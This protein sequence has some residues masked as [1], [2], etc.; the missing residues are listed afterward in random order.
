VRPAGLKAQMPSAEGMAPSGASCAF[1]RGLVPPRPPPKPPAGLKSKSENKGGLPIA[2]F[3]LSIKIISRGKGKSA[4]AAAAYRAGELIK[5]EY[6]GITHD[7]TRKGG[8]V[9]TEIMLPDNAPPEYADRATLWNSVEQVEKSRN[10][11]LAREIEIALPVE[12]TLPQNKSLVHDYIK[13][14]FVYAGICAD[15][16]IHDTGNGNPHAHIMLTMRPIEKNG[17]W[18][19]KAKKE[20]IL[21]DSGERVRL[22]SGEFKSRKVAAVDWNNQDKAEQWRAS[23]ADAV[24]TALEQRK[25]ESRID[26]RSYERQGIDRI[27]TIHLGVAA[28]Q[29]ERK[30]ISTNRGDINRE[31]EITNSQL[32][33]LEARINKLKARLTEESKFRDVAD[34]ETKVMDMHGKQR[35][36]SSKLND[37]EQRIK[38]LDEHIKQAG[39]YFEFR[40][41]YKKYKEVKPR[42]QEDYHENNRR[43]LALYESAERYLNGIMNGKTG[44]PVNAWKAER[45]KLTAEKNTLYQKYYSL[46]EEVRKAE[47]IRRD[48]QNIMRKEAMDKRPQLSQ[49][50]EL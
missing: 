32:R 6:D 49:G 36:L 42:K 3:H 16:C 7:Y 14:N 35:G 41:H 12:L 5:N 10:S 34:L 2:I 28:S 19:A 46:K 11:Q 1:E 44:L 23:W 21:D 22:K 50:M 9:Y 25:V 27:P 30:G 43:E 45:S 20:Y 29:M 33:Q 15:V 37:I 13:R 47:A 48:A 39:Y 24:N 17:E 18:G 38:T 31:A 8:V 40:P 4:V 26:H